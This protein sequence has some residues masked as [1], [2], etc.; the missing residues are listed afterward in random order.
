MMAHDLETSRDLLDHIE[1][2][3]AKLLASDPAFGELEDI[4]HAVTV[5]RDRR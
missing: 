3:A 1:R 4:I 5:L 2:I